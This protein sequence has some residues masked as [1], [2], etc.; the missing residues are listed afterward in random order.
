VSI[1]QEVIDHLRLLN[2]FKQLACN[3]Y[4]ASNIA[5]ILSSYSAYKQTGFMKK[6][7][8]IH[9]ASHNGANSTP[10]VWLLFCDKKLLIPVTQTDTLSICT[11]SPKQLEIEPTFSRYI[12]EHKGLDCFVAE[13][14]QSTVPPQGMDFQPIRSLFGTIDDD[15][16][17]LVGRAIQIL[18][19]NSEYRFCGKCGTIMKDRKTEFAKE[20]PSCGFISFPRISPAVIMSVTR[21]D[22][23]LLARSPHFPKG[24]YSTLAGFVEPGET[25]EEAVKREVFEESSIKVDNIQYVASQPW[26]FPHSLMIGFSAIYT[27]GEIRIDNMEIED[28]G[29][30]S[31]RNLPALPSKISIARLL[32]DN[33]ISHY[34]T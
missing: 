7:P 15:L 26:P 6:A 24:M 19:W 2:F 8:S 33:F 10:A 9:A 22:H 30:F 16:F 20:C 11:T 28:A 18:H 21:K 13:L 23:I 27:G 5:M 17:T 4:Q 14:P 1:H 31:T 29:W 25:L 12:G 3:T 32:I 34:S